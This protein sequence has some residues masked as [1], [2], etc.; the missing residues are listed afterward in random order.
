MV[1]PIDRISSAHVPYSSDDDTLKELAKHLKASI[2]AFRN[3]ASELLNH[4]SSLNNPAFIEEFQK[5]VLQLN[6][7]SL[8]AQ[9]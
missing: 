3:N 2:T 7:A 9:K 4:P 6:I 8:Q 1:G 5:R